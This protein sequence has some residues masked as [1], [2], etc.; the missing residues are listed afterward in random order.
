MKRWCGVV[1][2]VVVALSGCTGDDLAGEG[3]FFKGRGQTEVLI[4][5]GRAEAVYRGRN[6]VAQ[7]A[8]GIPPLS[9]GWSRVVRVASVLSG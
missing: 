1:C 3:E 4:L 7:G 6:D 9:E 2:G 8:V 5:A